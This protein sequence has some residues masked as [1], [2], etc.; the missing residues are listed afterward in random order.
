MVDNDDGEFVGFGNTIGLM[1]SK[2]VK[3]SKVNSTGISTKKPSS[4]TTTKKVLPKKGTKK[5]TT[6]S[7]TTTNKTSI[8][9][10][11]VSLILPVMD[12]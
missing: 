5:S 8:K 7:T 1:P 11:Q 10:Q 2:S 6:T 3:Q 9:Q 12:I 4:T